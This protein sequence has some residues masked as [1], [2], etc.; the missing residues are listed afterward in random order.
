[1]CDRFAIIG[2]RFDFSFLVGKKREKHPPGLKGG[3]NPV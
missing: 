2:V 1:M 3:E